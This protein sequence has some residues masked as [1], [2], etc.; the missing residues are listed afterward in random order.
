MNT[1]KSHFHQNLDNWF[2]VINNIYIIKL[3]CFHNWTKPVTEYWIPLTF[4]PFRAVTM[5]EKKKKKLTRLICTV[6]ITPKL[7]FNI[8]ES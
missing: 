4:R 1:C 6:N 2:S 7:F 3:P 8:A 5:G